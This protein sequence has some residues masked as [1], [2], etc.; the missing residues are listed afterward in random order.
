MG[1]F[2]SKVLNKVF[3]WSFTFGRKTNNILYLGTILNNKANVPESF[4]QIFGPTV[5]NVLEF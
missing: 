5:G 3:F 4:F 2:S 1:W